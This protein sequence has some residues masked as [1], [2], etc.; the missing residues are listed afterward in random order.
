MKIYL[1]ARYSRRDQMRE[2]AAELRRLGHTVT[3]RWLGGTHE[4]GPEGRSVEAETRLRAEFAREDLDDVLAADCVVSVTEAPD[5]KPSR[6]GRHVEFGVGLA[7]GKRL[8]VIGHRENVFHTLP[9]VE[10]FAGQ[11][12]LVRALGTTGG[13]N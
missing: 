12:D 5:A 9:Q 10:F 6:G 13:G 4:L 11:W 2:L 8:V 1:A 3:S 7:L